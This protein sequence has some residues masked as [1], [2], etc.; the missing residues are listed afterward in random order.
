LRRELENYRMAIFDHATEAFVGQRAAYARAREA[1][2]RYAPLRDAVSPGE[3]GATPGELLAELS[4]R[5]PGA[6]A[7]GRARGQDIAQRA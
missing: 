2:H 6:V 1:W 7:E 4:R 5:E 3:Q